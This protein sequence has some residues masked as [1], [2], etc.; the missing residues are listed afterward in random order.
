MVWLT[1]PCTPPS[2]LLM[3]FHSGLLLFSVLPLDLKLHQDLAQEAYWLHKHSWKELSGRTHMEELQKW[4]LAVHPQLCP[5]VSPEGKT[6]E[7]QQLARHK[8]RHHA[9]SFQTDNWKLRSVTFL[10]CATHVLDMCLHI[11]NTLYLLLAPY[12]IFFFMLLASS[13]KKVL[14]SSAVSH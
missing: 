2:Y 8:Q 5:M 7:H 13:R 6:R 4:E 1:P 3:C 9:L 11:Y 12:N 10:I 14:L